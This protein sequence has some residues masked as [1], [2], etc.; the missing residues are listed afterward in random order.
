MKIIINTLYLMALLLSNINTVVWAGD[1]IMVFK[2][3]PQRAKVYVDNI[4]KGEANGLVLSVAE[5]NHKVEIKKDKQVSKKNYFVPSDGVVK[6]T[7]TL[8]NPVAST[9]KVGFKSVSS[10]YGYIKVLS[11]P[12]GMEIY[13]NDEYVST[14][15][16]K[17]IKVD[18]GD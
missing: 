16:A 15:P 8:G 2:V 13:L 6:V 7:L 11:K 18:S 17:R 1:G 3:S 9:G 5:G 14:T 12:D 10:S 4:F